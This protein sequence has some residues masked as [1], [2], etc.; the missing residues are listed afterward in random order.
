MGNADFEA[1]G[2]R[3]TYEDTQPE[4]GIHDTQ[5]L[6]M[7]EYPILSR[8]TDG[9][10]LASEVMSNEM[11]QWL[12]EQHFDTLEPSNPEYQAFLADFRNQIQSRLEP[13]EISTTLEIGTPVMIE[14]ID[15]PPRRKMNV[16]LGIV[17]NQKTNELFVLTH[18]VDLDPNH[19]P[20]AASQRRS[21]GRFSP[22][23]F[24]LDKSI[25]FGNRGPFAMIYSYPLGQKA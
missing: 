22:P 18:A 16:I 14:R 12:K 19:K 25:P 5:G 23:V 6:I 13:Q 20:Y 3:I 9:P 2:K 17:K 24:L 4:S 1:A 7:Y 10:A 11:I 8:I 21:D 15:T